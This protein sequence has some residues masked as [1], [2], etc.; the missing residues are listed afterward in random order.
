MGGLFGA[1]LAAILLGAVVVVAGAWW[2]GAARAFAAAVGAGCAMVGTAAVATLR[3]GAA[4]EV[5]FA[6]AVPGGEWVF[7]IDAL[8]AFFLVAIAVVG[9][10]SAIYGIGYLERAEATRRGAV[11]GAHAGVAV[12]IAAL[13]L[14]VT[15]RAVMPFLIETT[16]VFKAQN[17]R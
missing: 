7:G 17:M 6:A 11:A 4:W 14:V 10:A 15:A 5:R 13:V 3:G 12:L 16:A 2:S 9:G 8:S 1:G